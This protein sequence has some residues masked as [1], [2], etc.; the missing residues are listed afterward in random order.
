MRLMKSNPITNN[1]RP[2]SGINDNNQNTNKEQEEVR[3][4]N[5]PLVLCCAKCYHDHLA[6]LMAFLHGRLPGVAVTSLSSEAVDQHLARLESAGS[7]VILMSR[8][9][10]AGRGQDELGLGLLHMRNG[11]KRVY[12]IQLADLPQKPTYLHV[13]FTTYQYLSIR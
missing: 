2:S 7:I 3:D 5:K 8:E 4:K 10:L 1:T 12:I 6:V 13:R 9:Y 11:S